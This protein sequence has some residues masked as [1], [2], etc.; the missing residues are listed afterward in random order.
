MRRLLTRKEI[1]ER[2]G[3]HYST[4]NRMMNRHEFIAP[5]FGRKRKLLFCPDALEAWIRSRQSSPISSSPISNPAEQNRKAEAD[6][7]ARQSAA[8][9]RLLAHAVGRKSVAK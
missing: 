2:L 7:A 1:C 8:K 4:L 6:F 5:V 3:I 9:I